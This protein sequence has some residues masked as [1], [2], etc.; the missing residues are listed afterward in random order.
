MVKQC[1]YGTFRSDTEIRGM[2]VFFPHFQ[3]PK[4]K[5]KGAGGGLNSV[6]D[7]TPTSIYRKTHICHITPAL[8]RTFNE[9]FVFMLDTTLNRTFNE[10]FVF[11]LDTTLNKTFNEHFV[12]MLLAFATA[13]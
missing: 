13:S 10:H 5:R 2:R 3:S 7:P 12:F 8:N 1:A 9:P 11:M 6:G 4:H